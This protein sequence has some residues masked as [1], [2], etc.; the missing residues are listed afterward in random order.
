M[1]ETVNLAATAAA[2][3]QFPS[4]MIVCTSSAAVPVFC[5]QSGNGQGHGG[6]RARWQGQARRSSASCTDL[7]GGKY[8]GKMELERITL[9]LSLA[10][11]DLEAHGQPRLTCREIRRTI[12]C[13]STATG[14]SLEQ[15]GIISFQVIT[16]VRPNKLQKSAHFA[17]S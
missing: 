15:G 9:E 7:W 2:A 5:F 17:K 6:A 13:V 16:G 4:A 1:V 3:V 11:T 8:K 12:V 14:G 10:G